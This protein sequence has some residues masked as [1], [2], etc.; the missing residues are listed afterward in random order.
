M[1]YFNSP[2][3]SSR[4][5]GLFFGLGYGAGLAQSS[6]PLQQNLHP[7]DG[8]KRSIPST[9]WVDLVCAESE[10]IDTRSGF[11]GATVANELTTAIP[12]EE[13]L[14][15]PRGTHSSL[16]QIADGEQWDVASTKIKRD[17]LNLEPLV[18]NCALAPAFLSFPDELEYVTHR[19]TLITS[20]A[21]NVMQASAVLTAI[22]AELITHD[23]DEKHG[24]LLA[25][26]R[27]GYALTRDSYL[28]TDL[29][30]IDKHVGRLRENDSRDVSDLRSLQKEN[31]SPNRFLRTALLTGF[32]TDDIET[33]L[34]AA[35]TSKW[36]PVILTS[37]VGGLMGARFGIEEF[38]EEWREA[39][40]E[41]TR[42]Q[43]YG[44]RM[45]Q[46]DE[47]RSTV[48]SHDR[49]FP[50]I[51]G[52]AIVGSTYLRS[53]ESYNNSEM[54]RPEPAPH[55]YSGTLSRNFTPSQATFF[56]WEHRAHRGLTDAQNTTTLGDWIRV[57]EYALVND[58]EKLPAQDVDRLHGIAQRACDYATEARDLY[59]DTWDQTLHHDLLG[60]EGS[61][62]ISSH[63]GYMIRSINRP[64]NQLG[65]HLRPTRLV[66][67]WETLIHTTHILVEIEDYM[68]VTSDLLFWSERDWSHYSG[69]V[70]RIIGTTGAIRQA[71]DALR[72][73]VIRHPEYDKDLWIREGIQGSEKQS[74]FK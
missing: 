11:D 60:E 5:K 17:S 53:G 56:D 38:P 26:L 70:P 50:V 31:G 23:S 41:G 10:A 13:E 66:Q 68:A 7:F 45:L 73:L 16:A 15:L 40:A 59:K 37:L 64:L 8:N 1:G 58:L 61:N 35:Q 65:K 29:K 22:V 54:L 12:E 21:T 39:F 51:H 2:T 71:I 74:P 27:R 24:E 14:T 9:S 49:E 62:R 69:L 47:R 25:N 6:S 19:S 57:P 43:Q 28:R 36:Q 72:G 63:L 33:A 18:R 42:L 32:G 20:G 44:R 34:Q 48:P 55:T 4:A 3:G 30:N 67:S 52:R 46:V